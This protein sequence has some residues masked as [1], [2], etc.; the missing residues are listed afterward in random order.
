MATISFYKDDTLY[1][2]ITQEAGTQI[3][4]PA[5][6]SVDYFYAWSNLPAD[7]IMPAEDLRCDACYFNATTIDTENKTCSA[8]FRGRDLTYLE[9]PSYITHD[10]IIYKV[11]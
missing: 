2:E 10:S 8:Q 7:N 9:I 3:E 5:E 6:P 4:L 11:I 1:A